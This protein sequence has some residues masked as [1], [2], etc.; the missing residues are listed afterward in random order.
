MAAVELEALAHADEA[1]SG[2]AEVL[3]DAVLRA[4]VG[5]LESSASGVQCT[6]TVARVGP[7]CLS[8]LVSASWTTR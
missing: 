6:D 1:L 3:R 5:D 7:A 2:A 4:G 8:V